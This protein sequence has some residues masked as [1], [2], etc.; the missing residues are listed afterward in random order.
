MRWAERAEGAWP[1]RVSRERR[2]RQLSLALE[3]CALPQSP[4][5]GVVSS[6]VTAVPGLHRGPSAAM[7]KQA[8]PGLEEIMECQVLWEPDSKKNT[9]MDRFRTAVGAACG[10]ALGE[11]GSPYPPG[12]SRK[13][14]PPLG[15]R[16]GGGGTGKAAPPFPG[17]CCPSS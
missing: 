8:R 12:P 9:Q 4:A 15:L 6:A 5:L 13:R 14:G 7:S 11:Y 1:G 10:L 17:R 16:G 2:P 3:P